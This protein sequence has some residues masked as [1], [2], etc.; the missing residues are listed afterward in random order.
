MRKTQTVYR[1]KRSSFEFLFNSLHKAQ[2]I[3]DIKS[4]M[5]NMAMSSLCFWDKNDLENVLEYHIWG[6]GQ[7]LK[8]LRRNKNF[9]S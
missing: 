2:R 4:S 5:A 3:M 1:L 6:K 7:F 8:I 9:I